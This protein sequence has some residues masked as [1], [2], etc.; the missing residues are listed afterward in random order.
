MSGDNESNLSIKHTPSNLRKSTREIYAASNAAISSEKYK[1]TISNMVEPSKRTACWRNKWMGKLCKSAFFLKVS[2]GFALLVA[3]IWLRPDTFGYVSTCLK[4]T[5]IWLYSHPEEVFFRIFDQLKLER[6][7]VTASITWLTTYLTTH[8]TTEARVL[9]LYANRVSIQVNFL[10]KNPLT[11]ILELDWVTVSEES[12]PFNQLLS[13]LLAKSRERPPALPNDCKLLCPL[14]VRGLLPGHLS[15]MMVYSWLSNY[16]SSKL[17]NNL[18]VNHTLAGLPIKVTDAIICLTFERD[19][20]VGYNPLGRKMRLL[21]IS[22]EDI[23]IIYKNWKRKKNSGGE[24]EKDQSFLQTRSGTKWA[25]MRLQQLEELAC[26]YHDQPMTSREHDSTRCYG[27]VRLYTPILSE[28]FA[29][30]DTLIAKYTSIS[31]FG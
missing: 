8:Y 22:K 24:S 10:T 15:D 30:D 13:N 31:K 27:I 12:L 19:E 23:E 3:Y 25:A 29:D 21:V 4:E 5:L 18:G 20:H 9:S 1:H 26:H 28:N 14:N 16:C 6:L 17:L 2:I 11:D 7:I